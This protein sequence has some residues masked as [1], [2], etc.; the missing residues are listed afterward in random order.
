[1]HLEI[2]VPPEARAGDSVPIV[3]RLVNDGSAQVEVALQGR[4]VAFDISV[5]R[6]DGSLV[7]RRL[8]GETVTAILQLR[9][10]PAGDTLVFRADWDQ[11]DA[12]GRPVPPGKYLV[13][14]VLPSDPPQ[15]FTAGPVKLRVRR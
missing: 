1:M 11:T 8:D 5:T 9:A 14:G 2:A 13:T 15:V 7:W 4:P 10:L 12:S 6:P 3:L